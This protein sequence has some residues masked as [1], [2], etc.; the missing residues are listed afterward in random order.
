M[1]NVTLK[2]DKNYLNAT[3]NL[4]H[5]FVEMYL[6]I[7]QILHQIE[8]LTE[9]R[10]SVNDD[11]NFRTVFKRNMDLCKFLAAPRR[12]VMLNV[13]YQEILRQGNWPRKC[14]FQPV[15]CAKLNVYFTNF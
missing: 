10:I 5:N 8:F 15:T 4:K 12:E 13:F 11:L 3:L 9:L 14:P 6:D 7:L 1:K 2:N